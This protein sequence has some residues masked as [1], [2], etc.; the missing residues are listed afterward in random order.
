ML[1]RAS[2]SDLRVLGSIPGQNQAREHRRGPSGRRKGGADGWEQ[3]PLGKLR[4]RFGA[5]G[6]PGLLAV[7][8]QLLEIQFQQGATVVGLAQCG[9]ILEEGVP[10]AELADVG[11][12]VE[13]G[14]DLDLG[15]G[16]AVG[17]VADELV[18][19]GLG[20]AGVF[21]G[22]HMLKR[23]NG[24]GQKKGGRYGGHRRGGGPVGPAAL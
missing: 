19:E 1:K 3:G 13:L 16:L 18:T 24:K 12:I 2:E 15:G 17:Q 7:E 11:K 5:R 6:L 10:G 21:A 14:E 20:E 8:G 9:G 4:Q 22:A 23:L